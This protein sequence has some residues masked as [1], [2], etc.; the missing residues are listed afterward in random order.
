MS[1]GKSDGQLPDSFERY[2]SFLTFFFC[3]LPFQRN[4]IFVPPE[5]MNEAGATLHPRL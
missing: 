4:S 5:L 2:L 3:Q 1:R